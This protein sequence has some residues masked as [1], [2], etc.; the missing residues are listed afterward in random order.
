MNLKHRIIGVGTIVVLLSVFTILQLQAQTPTATPSP[1]AL[2]P[3]VTPVLATETPSSLAVKPAVASSNP[4]RQAVVRKAVDGD[5]FDVVFT[6]D[7]TMATVHLANVDAP[8]SG[9]EIECFGREAAE[10]A[11]QSY[12]TNPVVS[13]EGATA[14][15]ENEFSAY[16]TLSDGSLLNEL[17]VLFGYGRF[18]AQHQG[19]YTDRIQAAEVQ[20]KKGNTGLWRACGELNQPAKPCFIFSQ[21]GMDSTSKR[22]VLAEYPDVSEISTS[23]RHVYYDPVQHEIV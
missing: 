6:D 16:I 9:G 18:D 4:A 8:N 13:I 3:T 22:E 15:A 10:Y 19:K 12:Q 2:T 21:E 1:S 7:G 5:S 17:V 11:A 14:T 23:F 20:S